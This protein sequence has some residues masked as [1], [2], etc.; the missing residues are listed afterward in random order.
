MPSMVRHQVFT[1]VIYFLLHIHVSVVFFNIYICV[2]CTVELH[3]AVLLLECSWYSFF[4]NNIN[5]LI[6]AVLVLSQLSFAQTV[7]SWNEQKQVYILFCSRTYCNNL[8]ICNKESK[9]KIDFWFEAKL[10]RK[11]MEYMQKMWTIAPENLRFS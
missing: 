9:K 3:I 8:M 5:V 4:F 2:I 10:F 1:C 7:W 11:L 6:F